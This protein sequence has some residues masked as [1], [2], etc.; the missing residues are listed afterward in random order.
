MLILSWALPEL[1]WGAPGAS[2][3]AP[4][5]ILAPPGLPLRFAGCLLVTSDPSGRRNKNTKMM[6][7]QNLV[8]FRPLKLFVKFQLIAIR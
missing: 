8:K 3:A 7:A 1:S 4:G 6:E 5:V 2:F